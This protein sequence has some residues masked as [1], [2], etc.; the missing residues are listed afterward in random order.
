MNYWLIFLLSFSTISGFCQDSEAYKLGVEGVLAIDQGN[1]KVGIKLLKMAWSKEP[2]SYDYPFEIGRAYLTSG[3]AKKAE[4]HFYPLQYHQNVQA[5]LYLHLAQAYQ[6]LEE[7]KN[8]PNPE[9]KR[10]LD[11]LRY[12]IQKLPDAGELYLQLAKRKIE[13]EE[14]VEALVVLESGIENA[15]NYAPNYFW[16]AKLMK[17]AGNHLWSW[18]YAEL[19]LNMTDDVEMSRTAA[20]LSSSSSQKVLSNNWNAEPEK[21]DQDLQFLVSNSCKLSGSAFEQIIE[22]RNCIS[23]LWGNTYYPIRVLLD[24][25]QTIEQQGLLQAYYATIYLEQNKDKFL[26]WLAEG[27]KAYERYKKWRYYNPMF[28]SKP[29]KRITY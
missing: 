1:T 26:P 27:G 11:A 13:L 8:N 15:P 24:R 3:D 17:A 18:I 6:Q 4:K 5:D 9:C 23:T 12:G 19:F 25:L 22:Q 20:L 21:M 29:I 2:S 28:V 14:P 16:A 7:Q 10:E